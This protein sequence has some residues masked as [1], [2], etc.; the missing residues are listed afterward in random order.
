MTIVILTS[1]D[2]TKIDLE[3]YVTYEISG[4]NTEGELYFDFDDIQFENDL[5]TAGGLTLV[6]LDIFLDELEMEGVVTY[7]I[8]KEE[9]L[10][11]GDV[12]KIKIGIDD[13]VAK[14]YDLKFIEY[15]EKIKVKGLE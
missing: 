9:N 3:D 2:R 15:D 12:I 4:S 11:N 6:Q 8:S 7:Y 14:K 10:S 13:D 1:C 5:L